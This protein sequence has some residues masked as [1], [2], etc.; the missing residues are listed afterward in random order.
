MELHTAPSEVLFIMDES[1]SDLIPWA[2][3]VNL[4]LGAVRK[5]RMWEE[6]G[7]ST[8]AKRLEPGEYIHN[9]FL[10]V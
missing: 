1:V 2:N 9:Y 6:A 7:D 5:R 10:K 3:E 8:P 4:A